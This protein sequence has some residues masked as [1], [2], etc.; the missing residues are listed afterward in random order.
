MHSMSSGSV[1]YSRT[2]PFQYKPEIKSLVED[3]NS[4]K[5]TH[6]VAAKVAALIHL[7]NE[8]SDPKS[9][10]VT[11]QIADIQGISQEDRLR[12]QVPNFMDEVISQIK[13]ETVQVNLRKGLHLIKNEGD[14]VCRDSQ[15]KFG[16]EGRAAC[17]CIC[18]HAVEHLLSGQSIRSEEEVYKIIDKGIETYR[19]LQSDERSL[20][21]ADEGDSDMTVF[22]EVLLKLIE[23]GVVKDMKPVVP[24]MKGIKQIN[25]YKDNPAIGISGQTAKDFPAVLDS[26]AHLSSDHQACAVLT[27][28]GETVVI[29]YPEPGKP[30]L[31]DSH[32]RKYEG[33]DK[34]ASVL[35]FDSN[36]ELASHL[37]EVLFSK[38]EVFEVQFVVGTKVEKE[39]EVLRGEPKIYPHEKEPA[40]PERITRRAPSF[41]PT[42]KEQ[43]NRYTPSR[44]ATS[45]DYSSIYKDR[46]DLLR[47]AAREVNGFVSSKVDL[48]QSVKVVSENHKLTRAETRALINAFAKTKEQGFVPE[49]FL[50]LIE[51]HYSASSRPPANAVIQKLE[52]TFG[53][54]TPN[55]LL[56]L[57]VLVNIPQ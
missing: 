38:T 52:A 3:L 33:M 31:F 14:I 45:E 39:T 55:Q 53:G 13:D 17:G 51:G 37:S 47:Q 15:G 12:E 28:N 23:K 43:S 22:S 21:R 4:N 41:A 19:E 6:K 20:F 29:S 1:P 46:N 10:I 2:N 18:L 48:F 11:L 40:S 27:C 36:R 5:D 35:K 44:G 50:H 57:K 8:G 34:G 24:D 25:F 49:P 9:I 42:S 32:G 16:P 26:L 56:A 7:L 30:T 54:L